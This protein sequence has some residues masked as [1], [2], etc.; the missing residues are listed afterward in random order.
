MPDTWKGYFATGKIEEKKSVKLPATGIKRRQTAACSLW[1]ASVHSGAARR[2][3]ADWT[4]RHM[5]QYELIREAKVIDDHRVA[6]VFD[7]GVSGV[8]DCAPYVEDA[9]WRRLK[10]PAFFRRVKVECG[11]LCWPDDIDI[12]PEEIWE[13]AVR[14]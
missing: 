13:G 2:R 7:N 8:F 11:T 4:C 6:V 10:S 12:D 1:L 3:G 9:Y 5:K 14:C